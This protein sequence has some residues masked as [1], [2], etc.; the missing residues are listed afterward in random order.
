MLLLKS[1]VR[2]EKATPSS[3][4]MVSVPAICR[5]TG[6]AALSELMLMENRSTIKPRYL[7]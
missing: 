2:L 5:F 7:V 1:P 3:F 4:A 6:T